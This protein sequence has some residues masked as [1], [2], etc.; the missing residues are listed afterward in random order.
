MAILQSYKQR[1]STPVR[2]RMTYSLEAVCVIAGG[3]ALAGA[4][5]DQLEP[6]SNRCWSLS[7]GVIGLAFALLS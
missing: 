4:W 1:R 7:F 5:I 3:Y 2:W 6:S